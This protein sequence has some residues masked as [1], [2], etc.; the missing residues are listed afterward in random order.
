V[1]WP[2]VAARVLTIVTTPRSVRDVLKAAARAGGTSTA[3]DVLRG[4]EILLAAKLVKL[5]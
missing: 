2:T 3:S 1:N 5:G 4:I